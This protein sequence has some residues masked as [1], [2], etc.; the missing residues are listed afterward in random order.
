MWNLDKPDL[1]A[2]C[3]DLTSIAEHSESFKKTSIEQVKALYKVYD[4]QKGKVTKEQHDKISKEDQ[5]GLRQA[6]NRTSRNDIHASIKNQVPLG[7]NKC[8]MCGVGNASTLD[9]FLE[10][11]DFKA[12][13]M[14]RQNMVPICND[15][16][17]Q[18]YYNRVSPDNF[19]HAY[20]DILPNDK[21]WLAVDLTYAAG[22][23]SADFYV[24]NNV[25]TDVILFR[26]ASNTITGLKLNDTIGKEIHSFLTSLLFG[27]EKSDEALKILLMDKAINLSC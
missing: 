21:Q 10:K 17:T 7:I 25:L 18:R 23:I 1:E 6:Y 15:C 20:Y 5:K 4:A 11:N 24:D 22:S 3:K 26:K 16:N 9:H 2:S 8:P 14:H 27:T 19:I 13:S 12:L